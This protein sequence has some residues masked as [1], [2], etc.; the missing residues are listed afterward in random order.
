MKQWLL[1]SAAFLTASVLFAFR[2]S[3]S[4]QV[5]D[6]QEKKLAS[7]VRCAPDWNAMEVWLQDADIPPMPG[8]GKH[9]WKISTSSDSAQFYFDQGMNMYYGFHIIES[10]ASFKKSRP[11][12]S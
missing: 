3:Q 2:F 10:M 9:H 7:L 5:V 12:R 4:K 6:I 1:F 11:F 8:A